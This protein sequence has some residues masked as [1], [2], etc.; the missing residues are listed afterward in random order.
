MADLKHW[1]AIYA[2]WL[3]KAA[4]RPAGA[5]PL[6]PNVGKRMQEKLTEAKE[7]MRMTKYRKIQ[8]LSTKEFYRRYKIPNGMQ[9]IEKLDKT[10]DWD[11]N[12]EVKSGE[13]TFPEEILE[14][15]TKYYEWLFSEKRSEAVPAEELL[16]E[17]DTQTLS[18]ED[19]DK[20]EGEIERTEVFKVM[21]DLPR[22]KAPG[23]DGIPN[24]YYKTFAILIA[25]E[26]TKM[27]N[28][29]HEKGEL[30]AD[31]KEGTISVLYKEKRQKRY[32]KL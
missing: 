16:R 23:P 1:E 29:T 5:A 3:R 21:R 4:N 2:H 31:V 26:F 15:A 12:P 8:E 11:N 27:L 10:S 13:T 19:S 28:E 30:G 20:C 18:K 14:E 17:L 6:N 24:E 22:D 7:K 25:D 9:W 32:P